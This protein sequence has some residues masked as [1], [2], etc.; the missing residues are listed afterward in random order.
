MV[1]LALSLK[2]APFTWTGLGAD[3]NWQTGLNWD[4][5]TP[6]SDGAATLTFGGDKRTD[7][8]NDFPA[9][10]VFA[11]ITFANDYSTGKKV[12]FTNSG[13]RIILGGNITTTAGT[14]TGTINDIIAFPI[15]LNG[16]RTLTIG[17]TGATNLHRLIITSVI[18]DSGSPY[19]LIKAGAGELALS[20]ANTYSGKTT[21]SGGRVWINSLA[22]V[23][24]GPSA[25]GN[26]ATAADGIIDVTGRLSYTGTVST[27]TDRM[28]RFTGGTTFENMTGNTT[29]TLTG[30]ITNT[31]NYGI[32]LRG[33]GFFN[34]PGLISMVSGTL[35]RTD[36]GILTLSNPNNIFGDLNVS[37]GI[38]SVNAVSDKGVSSAIGTGNLITLGQTGNAN[39]TGKFLFT[40][41]TGGS[42]NRDIRVLSQL[43]TTS[44]G[45]LE[46][47]VAGQTLTISGRVYR[48]NPS[49]GFAPLNLI[50]VGN[51][52]LSG[53]ISSNLCI[54]KAGTGTW[55]L[56][57]T[58][59]NV[60]T[61]Q[62]NAGT[63]LVNGT[64]AETSPFTVAAAG[65]L[66][67]TGTIYSAV[68]A[69]GTLSPA[70]TNIGT[71]TIANLT[72]NSGK[73]TNDLDSVAGSSDCIAVTNLLTLNGANVLTLR[74]PNG[75][76]P[77]G[78]YT[79]M[80]YAGKTGTGTLALDKTYPNTF[81]TVG[82]TAV[83][84]T[85]SDVLTWTGSANGTWDT[86]AANWSP[87][88]YSDGK[89]V[90]F[91]DTGANTT[92]VN[93][94]TPVA[95]SFITVNAGTKA[96]AIGGAGIIGSASLTKIGTNVLTLASTNTYTGATIINAGTLTLNGSISNSAIIVATN[97]VFTQSASGM[98][99]GDTATL[100]CQGIGTLNG[101]NTYGGLTAVGTP[102][103]IGRRLNVNHNNALGT[104]LAG[105]I[106]NGGGTLGESLLSLGNNVVI[107]G[108]AVTLNGANSYRSMLSSGATTGKAATWDGN[109]L[110]DGA[111]Y[112]RCENA[113]GTFYV[114]TTSEDTITGSAAGTTLSLRGYGTNIINSSVSIGTLSVLKD[115][116]GTAIIR[117]TGN[118][119]GE[120][121][122]V[123]GFITLGCSEALPATAKLLLG[124]SA[125]LSAV[126]FDLSGFTQ[127]VGIL[128]DEHSNGN[129][130]TQ[131]IT[132]ALPATL[133]VSNTVASSFGLEGSVIEGAVSL[134]K[135]NTGTLTLSGTNTMSGSFT[136][137]GGTNVI[138]ATGSLGINCTNVTIGA[139]T[140]KLLASDG[141]SDSAAVTIS[142]G[143][144]A[145]IDLVGVEETVKW[146]TFGEK[147]KLPGRYSATAGSGII[148][149]TEHFSGTGVLKVLRGPSATL[150]T[151][152]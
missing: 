78:V 151:F 122:V 36:G 148:V 48:G 130:G 31:G 119:W 73:L 28:I 110:I 74:F 138:T 114:G 127:T 58:N 113:G 91:D 10:T 8:V 6:T 124:K 123:E 105:T 134:V 16:T 106:V 141:I 120:A 29:V 126:T 41:P 42:C 104:T 39:T 121:R 2:A 60:G 26:P 70:D 87:I 94:A 56:S 135:A 147:P 102:G 19:G 118:V 142:D 85:I 107:T 109:I 84:I 5:G 47:N 40:G 81:L 66:G 33:G 108:E 88:N 24:S 131:R 22:N 117:S 125:K 21:I 54:L 30:V 92:S 35:G 128:V 71:L 12:A 65:T 97:A 116:N 15:L 63:L 51:G 140:L 95:P 136:L 45:A 86:T 144:A 14:L 132:S 150:I 129:G 13:A 96:Y 75:A 38:I 32:S 34:V 3:N 143:G 57:G 11:G 18:S 133:I 80:T 62:V 7:T 69:S 115:D 43:G 146:L 112:L 44:G 64:M 55:T 149:D 152:Q 100:T 93:I 59:S 17:Q 83:T 37:D 1:C 52:V 53:N 25:L 23:N 20:G 101:A 82:D 139:G 9:D 77:G 49:T 137:L 27:A 145:K 61:N 79:L 89:A 50:G 76:A 99:G 103:T 68:T 67:G 46:N 111:T 90:L 72:L 4:A 98:I